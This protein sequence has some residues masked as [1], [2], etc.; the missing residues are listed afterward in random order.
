[1]ATLVHLLDSP[2]GDEKSIRLHYAALDCLTFAEAYNLAI[3]GSPALYGLLPR[4]QPWVD[5]KPITA[6]DW[7]ATVNYGTPD[8]QDKQDGQMDLSFDYGSSQVKI[9]QSITTLGK[10]APAGMTA[11]DHKGAIGAGKIG[12]PPDGC[13]IN[14]PTGAFAEKWYFS[15]SRLTTAYRKTLLRSV[16]KMNAGGWRGYDAA[17]VL[18]QGVAGAYDANTELWGLSFK[19]AVSLGRKNFQVGNVT[20]SSARGW[21]Y[22]W[23]QYEDAIAANAWTKQIKGVYVEQLYQTMNF[24]DLGIGN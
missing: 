14:V 2:Q 12:Q 11:P 18:F 21:D 10:Y 7:D 9:T 4:K 6:V 16:G 24:G 22:V 5:I 13:D 17:E 8:N 19:F 20:I 23:V 1:M 3:L 15:N